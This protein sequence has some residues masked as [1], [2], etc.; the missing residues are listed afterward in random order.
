MELCLV[1]AIGIC[2]VNSWLYNHL[3][4]GHVIFE[5]ACGFEPGHVFPTDEDY[6]KV[7]DDEVR[8]VLRRIFDISKSKKDYVALMVLL[9]CFIAMCSL[10]SMVQVVLEI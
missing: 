10:K 5:M 8:E 1:S 3:F 2:P 7:E 4:S 9:S 6:Q